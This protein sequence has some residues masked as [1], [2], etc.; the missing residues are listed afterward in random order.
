MKLIKLNVLSKVVDTTSIDTDQAYKNVLDELGIPNNEIDRPDDDSYFRPVF[1]NKNV[2]IEEMLSVY[3]RYEN[4]EHSIIE[5]FDG[6]TMII[7]ITA[8]TLA[9]LLDDTQEI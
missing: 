1:I 9:K 8:N 2:L 4:N 6:R 7:D 5:Y 3:E